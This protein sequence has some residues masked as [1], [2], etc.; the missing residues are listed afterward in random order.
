MS[1]KPLRERRD[2]DPKF[3]ERFDQWVFTGKFPDAKDV[4]ALPEILE[5]TEA[6]A[7]LEKDNV[8]K[9][10]AVLFAENPALSSN[11]YSVVDRAS[12]ELESIALSELKALKAGDAPRVA[13]LRR[14]Q[15][16][17]KGVEQYIGPLS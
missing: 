3:M 17:L 7:A 8:Q 2:A 4:R 10:Q 6:L 14:L 1:K 13:K 12:E 9:A 5:N 16:A 15:L 11:L